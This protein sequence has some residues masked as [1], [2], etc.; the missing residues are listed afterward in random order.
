[1]AGNKIRRWR[2]DPDLGF[3]TST[4]EVIFHCSDEAIG[5]ALTDGVAITQRMG[6]TLVLRT[7]RQPT[8]MR[9]E[10]ITTRAVVEWLPSLNAE[11]GNERAVELSEV[12]PLVEPEP[13]PLDP[14]GELDEDAVTAEIG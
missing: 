10:A 12:P 14:E 3:Q 9:G 7:A 5:A 4:G 1:M 13:E 6:G 2:V 8:D 11:E